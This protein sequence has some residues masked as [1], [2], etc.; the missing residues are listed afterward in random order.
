MKTKK[1]IGDTF[2]IMCKNEEEKNLKIAMMVE[3]ARSGNYIG[4]S[5]FVWHAIAAQLGQKYH[6]V[7][8]STV[9]NN[10]KKHEL[11]ITKK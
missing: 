4:L 1:T 9:N 3:V 8:Y 2:T 11:E 7:D 6:G 5:D 10:N